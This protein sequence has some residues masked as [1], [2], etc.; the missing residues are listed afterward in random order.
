[1]ISP[2]S[3]LFGFVFIDPIFIVLLFL[4][5]GIFLFRRRAQG[6]ELIFSPG[7]FLPEGGQT[8]ATWRRRLVF[9]PGLLMG[10]GIFFL[11][12]ALMRPA[13]PLA[14]K[15][16]SSGIE[17]LLCVDVSSSMNTLDMKK[18]NR[19]LDVA[20]RSAIQFLK[21]RHRDRVGLIKFA[22]Y[23]DLVCPLTFD[24]EALTKSLGDLKLVDEGGPEDA[25]G[26]GTALAKGVEVLQRNEAGSK[27]IVLLTDGAENVSSAASP[28]EIAPIHGAQLC[29]DL[30]I[31]VHIVLTG[32]GSL[33]EDGTWQSVDT[34]QIELV[35]KKT[36]GRFF[37]AQ[38]QTALQEV[39]SQIDE[40][41]TKELAEEKYQMIDGFVPFLIAGFAFF[42]LGKVVSWTFLEVMP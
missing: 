35:A 7:R 14:M 6:P 23:P 2:F 42:I 18:E 37:R 25:T 31:R 38:D 40:L 36:G 34:S 26:I 19:R 15:D 17:L 27:V 12:L 1:M 29:E 3:T 24:H 11:I 16:Q 4:L 13:S 20:S 8:T 33:Q 22:R 39:F 5:P 28:E 32:S 10:L 21:G 30:G 9:L 41:E